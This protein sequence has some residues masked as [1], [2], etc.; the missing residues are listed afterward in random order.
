MRALLDRLEEGA[1][2]VRFNLRST[3]R[4]DW[5]T[6]MLGDP[7]RFEVKVVDMTPD[8]FLRQANWDRHPVRDDNVREIEQ[9]ILAGHTE[10]P[11]PTLVYSM[12]RPGSRP[13]IKA[14]FGDGSHRALAMKNLGVRKIKVLQVV[15]LNY[16][17]VR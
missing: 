15:D 8:E 2:T 7:E 14:S 6:G 13:G 4:A 5:D 17:H 16:P 1:P 11:T 9:S 10:I 12:G 3:G